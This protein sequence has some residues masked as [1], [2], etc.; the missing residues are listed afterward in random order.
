MASVHANRL[1][2]MNPLTLGRVA[3]A[4]AL[5]PF[6]TTHVSYLIAASQGHV[7]WC[8]P[9]WD[10]CTSISATGRQMPEKLWFKLGMLPTAVL[11]ALFWR[12]LHDWFIQSQPADWRRTATG[13]MWLG[14]LAAVFLALYTLAL[15]EDGDTFRRMR[16]IGVT[17]A[18]A[19]TFLAQ[20]LATQ[21]FG[22]VARNS[23]NLPLLAHQQRLLTLLLS[24][25][26]VGIVS[27][28]LDAMLGDAYDEVEDA[29]EWVMA[30]MLNLW[31]A[32]TALLLGGLARSK[33]PTS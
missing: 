15:G 21:L 8:V 19:L 12:G 26:G 20:L 32:G 1:A 17:L 9:Y 18:F 16:R 28:M 3:W 29:F 22:Q 4:C 7:D 6:L 5:L 14:L 23:V 25:L 10:S 30:L 13:M 11:T 2:P 33:P 24:L 27:V 31:F